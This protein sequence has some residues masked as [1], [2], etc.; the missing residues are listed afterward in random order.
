MLWQIAGMIGWP[1]ALLGAGFGFLFQPASNGS[2]ASLPLLVYP[3][4]LVLLF[5]VLRSERPALWAW[6][7]LHLLVTALFT[8]VWYPV[9]NGY[10]FMVG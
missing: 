4:I 5:Y 10:D 1:M 9:L 8:A 2:W 7:A 6:S 3:A